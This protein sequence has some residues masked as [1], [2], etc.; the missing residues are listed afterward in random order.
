MTELSPNMQKLLRLFNRL[1]E[2]ANIATVQ[3][4]SMGYVEGVA[5]TVMGQAFDCGVYIAMEYPNLIG[6]VMREWATFKIP[7]EVVD[8]EKANEEKMAFI[9]ELLDI[10]EG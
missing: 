6:P 9:Q 10:L 3:A 1:G 8:N 7:G 2:H 4:L 5:A